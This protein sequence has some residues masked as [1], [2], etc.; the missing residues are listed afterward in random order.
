M[1]VQIN[2]IVALFAEADCGNASTKETWDEF[3]YQAE[4][5]LSKIPDTQSLLR[6]FPEISE[7]DSWRLTII[8][9]GGVSILDIKK[10]SGDIWNVSIR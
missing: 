6:T 7:R 4:I 8:S 2:R 1:R 10:S 5:A 3:E 9:N